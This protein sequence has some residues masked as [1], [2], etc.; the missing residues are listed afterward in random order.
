MDAGLFDVFHDSADVDL[1]A[2]AERVDVDL[3]R[4]LQKP[5]DQHRVFG[6]EF[7]G[8]GDVALQGV[9]VVD[10]F[11][12]PAAQHVRRPHQHRITDLRGDS[13]GLGERRGHAVARG[14]QPGSREQV[15]ERAAV[16]GQIDGL[17]RRADNRDARVEEPLR[18]PQRRLAAELHD[19]TDYPGP[20]PQRTATRRENTSRTSSKVSGSKYSRS[21]VS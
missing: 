9:V 12:A 18:Q 21:A 15:A 2:V 10:D 8:A 19:D 7:G 5:V 4:V 20:R 1:V 13:A 17:R 16:L 3:D 14:R 11:H 6:R